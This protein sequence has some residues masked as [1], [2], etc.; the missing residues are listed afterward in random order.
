MFSRTNWIVEDRKRE[1]CAVRGKLFLILSLFFFGLLPSANHKI[2]DFFIFSPPQ[3]IIPPDFCFDLL[4]VSGFHK[5]NSSA[6]HKQFKF[7]IFTQKS[8]MPDRYDVLGIYY[9]IVQ[10]NVKSSWRAL[11]GLCAEARRG[12]KGNEQWRVSMKAFCATS[13]ITFW[14]HIREVLI[15]IK[16]SFSWC[17]SGT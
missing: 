16:L 2:Y 1:I 8:L 12:W 3:K 15:Y 17:H 14:T 11:C 10:L 9:R 7:L 13:Q 4:L 6:C 5:I